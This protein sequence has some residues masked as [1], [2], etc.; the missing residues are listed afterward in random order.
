MLRLQIIRAMTGLPARVR[1]CARAWGSGRRAPLRGAAA[2]KTGEFTML[3]SHALIA[4]PGA[5]R[6]L[7]RLC[8]SCAAFGTAR[9]HGMRG[10]ADLPSGH[11]SM[12]AC[13]GSLHLLC[14]SPDAEALRR[15]E[16]EIATH[17]ADT[18]GAGAESPDWREAI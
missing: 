7:A 9:C 6:A 8:R 4:A 18:L 13:G 11:C 10:C 5:E 12:I 2:V 3:R 14:E 15:T 1:E 16:A 17:L